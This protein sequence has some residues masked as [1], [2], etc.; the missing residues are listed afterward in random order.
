MAN[1]LA[2]RTNRV[3]MHTPHKPRE[4]QG[5]EPPSILRLPSLEYE[6]KAANRNVTS[7]TPR[8]AI[9][10]FAAWATLLPAGPT[11]GRIMHRKKNDNPDAT[12]KIVPAS[13]VNSTL[14]VVSFC[15]L[16]MLMVFPTVVKERTIYAGSPRVGRKNNLVPAASRF[17]RSPGSHLFDIAG[18]DDE[19]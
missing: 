7:S 5:K 4:N 17:R 8:N 11:N 6:A 19:Q 12:A 10:L 9:S 15:S 16:L 3:R 18:T 2:R 14:S 1:P 13:G